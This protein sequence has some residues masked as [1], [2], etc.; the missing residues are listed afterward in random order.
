MSQLVTLRLLINGVYT[1]IPLYAGAGFSILRGTA[2]YSGQWPRP[3]TFTVEINNDSLDYDPE[4]PESV[5]YGLAGISTP[6]RISVGGQIRLYGEAT[7]YVPDRTPEHKAGLGRGRSW[8]AFTA[9]GPLGRY[10]DWTDPVRPPMT[11][12]ISARPTSLGHWPLDDGAQGRALSNTLPGGQPGTIKG[13]PTLGDSERPYGAAASV[14]L[15]AGNQLAFNFKQGSGLAWQLG[16]S[17]KIPTVPPSGYYKVLQWNTSNGY[18]WLCEVGNTTWRFSVFDRDGST[19]LSLSPSFT[20]NGPDAWITVRVKV[21]SSGGTVSVEPAWY[22]QGAASTTGTS[23]TFT[24]LG[25]PGYLTRA[26]QTGDAGIAG[27]WLAQVFAVTGSSDNL[28]SFSALQAFNGYLGERATDR[29]FRVAAAELDVTAFLTGNLADGVAMGVEPAG[30]VMDILQDIVQTDGG[31]IDDVGTALGI[32]MVTRRSMAGRDP[33]LTLAYPSQVAP[34]FKPA[35]GRAYT[36]NVITAKNRDAG[37][38][39]VAVTSGPISTQAPPLGVNEKRASVDVNVADEG[40]DLLYR[41]QWEAAR[42][43]VPGRQFVEVTVDLLAHPE[44]SAGV[45]GVVEG[46]HILVTGYPPSDIHL[47]VTGIRDN[48]SAIERT[49]TF[50]CESYEIMRVPKWTDGT[51]RWGVGQLATTAAMTATATSVTVGSANLADM[52]TPGAGP[53]DFVVAGEQITVATIGAVSG[54]G[55]YTQTLSGI[56]RSVNQVVKAQ[57]VGAGLTVYNSRR[58]GL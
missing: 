34:P 57:L 55:P 39:T 18:T 16:F 32:V 12:T 8:V 41:A 30:T 14:K 36:A 9:S 43:T 46:D 42:G 13:A 38:V 50:E 40:T 27:S 33:K 49:V 24:G 56:T 6:A 48:G 35:P 37:E 1:L 54:T 45:L 10:Q 29:Y 53:I 5:L 51:W 26:Y 22:R 28:I 44:L 3:A 11:R 58:W 20:P 7:L 23:G 17:F 2:P 31:R 25:V 19:L 47:W 52:L 4:R 15:A 21:S